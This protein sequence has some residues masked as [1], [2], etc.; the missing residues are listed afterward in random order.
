MAIRDDGEALEIVRD[1]RASWWRW[2]RILGMIPPAPERLGELVHPLR[3]F[4]AGFGEDDVARVVAQVS[5]GKHLVEA[6]LSWSEP[7]IGPRRYSEATFTDRCRGIQWSTVMAYSGL[8]R[9]IRGLTDSETKLGL[10]GPTIARFLGECNL[11]EFGKPLPSPRKSNDAETSYAL[12]SM[13]SV[14]RGFLDGKAVKTWT[15]AI[16]LAQGLRNATVH[17]SLSAS[18][19]SKSELWPALSRLTN[20]IGI[21]M[22]RAIDRLAEPSS[23]ISKAS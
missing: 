8:E 1:L 11:A 15:D 6:A 20:V 3:R 10:D 17:G 22:V 14:V 16:C 12:S 21:V 5:Q 19:V 13:K 7:S 18:R 9:A 23:T 4:H 2:Y